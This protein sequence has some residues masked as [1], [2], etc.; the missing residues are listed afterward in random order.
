MFRLMQ[1]ILPLWGR[2]NDRWRDRPAAPQTVDIDL[3]G[4]VFN[5]NRLS[6]QHGADERLA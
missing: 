4:A 5:N 1:L 2:E 3:Q 6:P